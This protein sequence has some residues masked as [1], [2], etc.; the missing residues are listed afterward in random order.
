V[1]LTIVAANAV[2]R[3]FWSTARAC[4]RVESHSFVSRWRVDDLERRQDSAVDVGADVAEQSHGPCTRRF[5]SDD[6]NCPADLRY[7]CAG[8]DLVDVCQD[9][10]VDGYC[11]EHP[12]DSDK[13]QHLRELTRGCS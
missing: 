6:A 11:R 8:F 2:S 3:A 4:T 1:P 5:D 12:S 7:C 10:Y 13:P 9:T